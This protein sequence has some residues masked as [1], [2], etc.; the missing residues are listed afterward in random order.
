LTAEGCTSHK[1]DRNIISFSN[2]VS[3]HPPLLK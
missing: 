2:S 3:Q 1:T